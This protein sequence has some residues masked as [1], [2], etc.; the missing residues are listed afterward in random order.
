VTSS[1]L[2][3]GFWMM[4]DGK[5]NCILITYFFFFIKNSSLKM[6]QEGEGGSKYSGVSG[7]RYVN[8]QRD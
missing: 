8:D 7:F 6:K 3:L 4:S 1:E 2:K 5:L